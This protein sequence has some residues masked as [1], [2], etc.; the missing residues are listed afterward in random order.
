MTSDCEGIDDVKLTQKSELSCNTI[1]AVL[2]KESA[3]KSKVLMKD[4][5]YFS[6]SEEAETSQIIHL[7]TV[8]SVL[9][10]DTAHGVEEKRST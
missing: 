7:S 1:M 6:I 4:I 8:S 10:E 2:A 5:N 9:R 3:K